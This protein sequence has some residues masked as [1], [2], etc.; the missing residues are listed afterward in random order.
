[1]KVDKVNSASFFDMDMY[2]RFNPEE[3]AKE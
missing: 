3:E 1:L 2:K